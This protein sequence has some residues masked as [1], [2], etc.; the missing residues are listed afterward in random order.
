MN[1]RSTTN[2]SASSVD[3]ETN[4]LSADGPVISVSFS[5]GSVRK[6]TPSPMASKRLRAP[7]RRAFA[8]RARRPGRDRAWSI[9]VRLSGHSFSARSTNFSP[10]MA[11]LQ[12]DVRLLVPAVLLAVQEMVEEPQLQLAAVVGV[13]M[14]PVLDAVHF[15][16]LVLGG[17]PHEALEIAARMQR[18]AAPVGG[19][20][21][22]RLDLRPDR[23][24]RP[25]VVVVER[26]GAD[27]VAEGA[28]VPGELGLG[29]GL[30]PAA[31]ARRGS[32]DALAALARAVLHG[33]HLHVVPVFPERAEDAAVMRH[34]AVPVGG[35]LPDAHGGEV[36]RLQ[37]RHVPLVDAVI[38][39]AVEPDLAVRPG[40]HAGPFDAIV[41]VLGLA[42]REMIDDAGRAA[43]AA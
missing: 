42:R 18:L 17:G 35:A 20:E 24:A 2:R 26:M 7:C 3:D 43:A 27:V 8:R 40:L 19:R 16:P 39:D 11:D 34:V 30:R 31:P 21:K 29:Q 5:S 6:V 33:L 36:R 13:E 14:R 1:T 9:C 4:S 25:V 10:V 41:E 37:R 22:R 28:A 32:R 12:L 38:R 23:R 15:Q